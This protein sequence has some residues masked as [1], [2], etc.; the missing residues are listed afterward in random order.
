MRTFIA[1]AKPETLI[2]IEVTLGELDKILE[3]I[4]VSVSDL[5]CEMFADI[6]SEEYNGKPAESVGYITGDTEAITDPDSWDN[7]KRPDVRFISKE[8]YDRYYTEYK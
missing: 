6:A 7:E 3:D 5:D 8:Y 2:M 4:E 1:Q